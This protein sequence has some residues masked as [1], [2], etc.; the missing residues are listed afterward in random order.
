MNLRRLSGTQGYA[1]FVAIVVVVVLAYLFLSGA[2]ESGGQD[3]QQ[4]VQ[5]SEAAAQQAVPVAV[6]AAELPGVVQFEQSARVGEL[7]IAVDSVRWTNEVRSEGRT[8]L[9]TERFMIV[10]LSAVNRGAE[11]YRLLP[12]Q[13][14]IVA[15]DG[16]SF[17]LDPLL[18]AGAAPYESSPAAAPPTTLQPGLAVSLLVIFPMPNDAG[19]LSLRIHGHYV[20]FALAEE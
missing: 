4:E 7:D 11:P 20:D 15:A 19:G 1:L 5:E 9:A 17:V 10:R 8:Q 16:R 2:L 14:Q 3:G 6:G 18:S 12:E 13:I